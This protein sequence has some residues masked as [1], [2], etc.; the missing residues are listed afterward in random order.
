MELERDLGAGEV[1]L[2]LEDEFAPL[3]LLLGLQSVLEPRVQ[4]P[5]LNVCW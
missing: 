2:A 5:R 3:A 1:V 4:V